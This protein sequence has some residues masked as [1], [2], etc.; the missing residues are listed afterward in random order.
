MIDLTWTK[1]GWLKGQMWFKDSLEVCAQLVS[2]KMWIGTHWI[3]NRW[4]VITYVLLMCKF[5]MQVDASS[6]GDKQQTNNEQTA[7]YA[8]YFT[9]SAGEWF[10]KWELCVL[11]TECTGLNTKFRC[12]GKTRTKSSPLTAP[13]HV[14]PPPAEGSG[15]TAGCAS[16]DVPLQGQR[17]EDDFSTLTE[18]PQVSKW[19]TR[20]EEMVAVGRRVA[21]RDTTALDDHSL[22]WPQTKNHFRLSS[23]T[24][25]IISVEYLWV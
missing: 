3:N 7:V 14:L 25:L 20:H 12:Y 9:W 6:R 2:W 10:Q 15:P 21:G 11:V 16:G 8:H 5:Y 22:I 17:H 24:H 4:S 23:K 13:P 1:Q 18:K 19:P